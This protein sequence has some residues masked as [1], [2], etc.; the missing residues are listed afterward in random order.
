MQRCCSFPLQSSQKPWKKW[1]VRREEEP[2][3]LNENTG[4]ILAEFLD[5]CMNSE[6]LGKSNFVLLLVYCT[7]SSRAIKSVGTMIC[8]AACDPRCFFLPASPQ[9]NFESFPRYCQTLL[10]AKKINAANHLLLTGELQVLP[11]ERTNKQFRYKATVCFHSAWS[12]KRGRTLRTETVLRTAK[13][14][15]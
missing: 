12:G 2:E 4:E 11:A 8:E 13:W 15:N 6:H 1:K 5:D 14:E 7:F 9:L 3:C 10:A